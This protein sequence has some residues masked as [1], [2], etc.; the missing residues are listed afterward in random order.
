MTVELPDG[1]KPTAKEEYMSPNQLEYFRQK[2]LVYERSDED[3][4]VCGALIRHKVQGQRSTYY[5]A[6]CQR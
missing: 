6:Q 4:K 5:C 3:C 2:L 1:Y